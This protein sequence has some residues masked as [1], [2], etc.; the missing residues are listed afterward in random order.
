M[1]NDQKVKQ[2]YTKLD[3]QIKASQL[4]GALKTIGEVLA[5]VPKDDLATRCKAIAEVKLSQ[6]EDALKTIEKASPAARNELQLEKAYA[7][8]RLNKLD[9]ALEAC[10][11]V[12]ESQAS[13]RLQLEAQVLYRQGNAAASIP[14]Y[15]ELIK[16]HQETSQDITTNTLAAYVTGGRSAEVPTVMQALGANAKDRYEVAYNFACSLVATE[17][18]PEAEEWLL[19]AQ[20]LGQETLF[21]DELTEE[22]VADELLPV[23]VQLGYVAA[24]AGRTQE[25]LD[26]FTTALKVDST[27]AASK[28]VATNN[29]VAARGPR[30]LF[31]AMK[32]LDRVLAS[33]SPSCTQLS[34]QLEGRLSG[35]QQEAL[36]FTRLLVLMHSNKLEPCKALAGVLAQRFPSSHIPLMIQ[37]SLMLRERKEKSAAGARAD[38]TLAAFAKAHPPSSRHVALMRA[39]IAAAAGNYRR[40]ADLLAEIQ[41]LEGAL[42]VA[43]TMVALYEAA[44][45]LELAEAVLSTTLQKLEAQPK[46]A[47]AAAAAK[48]LRS[49]AAAFMA[50]HGRHQQAAELYAALVKDGGDEE[51]LASLVRSSA[52]VDFAAAQA[53]AQ[54]LPAVAGAAEVDL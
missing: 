50:K 49:A 13:A 22:E 1:D 53:H 25:A 39:Q 30:E 33:P 12:P 26:L 23:T 45:E 5:V 46:D 14:K 17:K 3:T 48:Q 47:A 6:F 52:H 32:R 38:E 11:S 51:V 34:P 19:L 36:L 27:D 43:A 31:D 37:A 54:A 24:A 10:A 21:E 42:A 18:V 29:L 8:Y 40:A 20:R 41:E 16:T 35:A 28:A 44:G 9:Q 2:L 15:D 7:L 4:K